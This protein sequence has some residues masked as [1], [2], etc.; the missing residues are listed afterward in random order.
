MN[1]HSKGRIYIIYKMSMNI[2]TL[3]TALSNLTNLDD[4]LGF[5]DVKKRYAMTTLEKKVQVAIDG[6]TNKLSIKRLYIQLNKILPLM[7]NLTKGD[8]FL[9]TTMTRFRNIVVEKFGKESPEHTIT[10]T[11]MQVTAEAQ[12]RLKVKAGKVI[13]RPMIEVKLSK[14]ESV[15][16]QVSESKNMLDKIIAIQLAV[17]LRSVEVIYGITFKK[18]NNPN[19]IIQTEVMKNAKTMEDTKVPIKPMDKPLLGLSYNDF[20]ALKNK[21]S[22]Y[23]MNLPE[24]DG[25]TAQEIAKALNPKLNKRIRS[26][27]DNDKAFRS[28]VM[29]GIYVAVALKK[30]GG[31][32]RPNIFIQSILGHSVA[33]TS[34]SYTTVLLLDDKI[35]NQLTA[36]KE[37]D[38]AQQTQIDG[39]VEQHT[40]THLHEREVKHEREAKHEVK[41]EEEPEEEPDDPN[42]KIINGHRFAYNIRSRGDTYERM[43][44]LIVRM[45]NVGITPTSKL[46]RE[47]KYSGR[48]TNKAVSDGLI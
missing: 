48:M 32:Q 47:L 39:L 44:D 15:F 31:N 12:V 23:Y 25:K 19:Y 27:F 22:T 6:K 40:G 2:K 24:Y 34:M 1:Y 30:Y 35:T 28:H 46:L 29:R 13:E 7:V 9:N 41:T 37:T 42:T 3:T 43:K 18:S 17:G 5:L 38:E 20:I 26:L 21:V 16:E 45:S 36:L 4:I 11:N 8:G 33:E 10:L 14:V